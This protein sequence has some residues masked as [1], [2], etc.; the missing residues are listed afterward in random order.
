[1]SCWTCD[2]CTLF[3][4][5]HVDKCNACCGIRKKR[6]RNDNQWACTRCTFLND[7]S[8]NDCEICASTRPVKSE[9]PNAFERIM[10]G[11]KK[12]RIKKQEKLCSA[13]KV[14]KE[15]KT[16]NE[17]FEEKNVF[18]KMMRAAKGYAMHFHLEY[19]KSS[20]T[21]RCQWHDCTSRKDARSRGREM[22]RI[23]WYNDKTILKKI[24]PVHWTFRDTERN[25]LDIDLT[26][27]E[28]PFCNDSD[29]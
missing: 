14:L 18:S 24:K 7:I 20:N 12:K 23:G 13:I 21:F 3:N 1:M 29:Y 15:V 28:R 5:D 11:H 4:P 6:K 27:N 25:T 26:D 8:R 19:V 22:S 16:V 2:R 9:S 10:K 17:S